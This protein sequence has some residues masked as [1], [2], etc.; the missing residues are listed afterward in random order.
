MN[1]WVVW[2]LGWL[3]A[4]PAGAETPPARTRAPFAGLS[5]Q[6]T[7]SNDLIEAQFSLGA[8]GTFGFEYFLDKQTGRSWRAPQDAV[9]S[10]V[11]LTVDGYALD[12][13][14][15]YTLVAASENETARGG[16]RWT[17]VLRAATLPGEIRWEMET[18]PGQPFLR[19]QYSYWNVGSRTAAVT[20]ADFLP[21]R[22]EAPQGPLRALYVYQWV[23]PG[24]VTTGETR[25]NFEVIEQRLDRDGPVELYTGSHALHTTWVAL[26]D[27]EDY[28]LAVGWG[29]TGRARVRVEQRT[30]PAELA[31]SGLPEG[32]SHVVDPGEWFGTPGA[33][34]GV[35][36][37]DWDEAGYRTQRFAEAA[38]AQPLPDDQFPYVIWDSWGH[39]QEIHEAMLRRSAEIAASLGVEVFT[40]D[41]GWARAMGDWHPDPVKFPSGLKALS[42]YVHSLGM[43]FGL[44]FALAQGDG[45]APVVQQHPD[46]RAGE[47]GWY[48]FSDSLCLAHEP[49]K[50]WLIAEGVRIIREYGV[51]WV[52]QDGENMVKICNNANHTH[53]PMDSNYSNAAEGLNQVIAAIQEATPG[54]HWENCEDGAK[55][56]T[57]AVMKFYVTSI[58]SDAGN[59]FETRKATHGQTFPFPLR[60][61]ARYMGDAPADPYSTRSFMVGGPLILMQRITELDAGKLQF[62]RQE[63]ELYKSIRP[64]YRHGRV[65]HLTAQPDG[66]INDALQVVDPDSGR[67]VVFVYR[68]EGPQDQERIFP[69]GLRPDAFYSVRREEAGGG[70]IASGR[71]LMESGITVPLPRH[72][73]AEILHLDP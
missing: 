66:R 30:K 47:N 13:R 43:K 71:E 49:V 51:N 8:G 59:H 16:R 28:G 53:H 72:Y 33:F 1:R 29:F 31:F 42:D 25:A 32:L 63:I 5:Y 48:Y 6:W 22:L 70:Q 46:W 37:G 3:L 17:I 65:Y 54:V 50:Q 19:Y 67:S 64:L 52:L 2:V 4:S 45:S 24:Q 11:R 23:T 62:L 10:P 36:Q 55:M 34:L 38:V 27:P 14:T 68:Q 69:R 35:F 7:A 58:G 60:Y 21:W 61:S 44:H 40:V 9:V 41:L 20:Q 18:Y 39:E 26:R 56:M 57:Y 12:E 73:Y 15:P